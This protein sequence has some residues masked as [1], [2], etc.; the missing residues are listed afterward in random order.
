MLIQLNKKRQ[1]DSIFEL[2]KKLHGNSSLIQTK[3]ATVPLDL[4]E[5]KKWQETEDNLSKLTRFRA[6]QMELIEKSQNINYREDKISTSRITMTGK[7]N[8][9]NEFFSLKR[10]LAL[11]IQEIENEEENN[12]AKK[13]DL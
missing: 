4:N 9:K 11:V 8:E 2:D 10:K 7:L 6:L 5:Y 12:K 13:L 1:I 3:N